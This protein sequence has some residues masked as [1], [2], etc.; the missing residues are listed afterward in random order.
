MVLRGFIKEIGTPREWTSK[1]SGN[2]CWTYPLTLSFE[3]TNRKGETK[4]DVVIADHIV[5][6]Q[7]YVRKLEELK[8]NKSLCEMNLQFKVREYNEKMY[9]D[10]TLWDIQIMLEK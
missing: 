6:N 8:R 10:A 1:Q 9:Q 2:K 4:E 5:G 7:D 3:H